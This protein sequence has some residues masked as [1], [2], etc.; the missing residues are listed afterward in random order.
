VVGGCVVQASS[1]R[2]RSAA[3]HSLLDSNSYFPGSS[4][5]LVVR[6]SMLHAVD[7]AVVGEVDVDLVKPVVDVGRS[8]VFCTINRV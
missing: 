4:I 2:M 3:G 5:G 7:V 6:T 1:R 8:S